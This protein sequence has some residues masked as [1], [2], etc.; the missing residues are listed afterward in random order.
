MLAF[1][2]VGSRDKSQERSVVQEGG[3]ERGGKV[4][5]EKARGLYRYARMNRGARE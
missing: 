2:V 1:V 4:K 3:E 5:D